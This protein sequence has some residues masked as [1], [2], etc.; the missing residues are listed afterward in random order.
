MTVRTPIIEAIHNHIKTNPLSFHVPGHKNGVIATR[1]LPE[2]KQ[3]FSYDL[4]ELDG[5]DDL[6]DASGPIKASQALCAKYYGA[7]E[8]SYLVGGSTS[9]NLA[10][11]YGVCHEG[12]LVFVQRNCHKS[13]LNALEF[14]RVNVVFLEPEKSPLTG[15]AVG[16]TFE[17]LKE[18]LLTYPYAKAIIMTYPDY[19]GT[20]INQ[21]EL[22]AEAKQAGL[23]VL[24]DEAHGAHFRIGE[25]DK[26]CPQSALS[27]GADVVVQSTHKMLPSL[28]MSAWMHYSYTLNDDIKKRIKRALSMFQ[29][30][31]PSYLLL[32]SLDA[33]RAHIEEEGVYQY[34]QTLESKRLLIE[35]LQE[36]MGLAIVE[37]VGDAYITDP[38][39]I[40]VKA[41]NQS[42]R[43]L[44]SNLTEL[45]IWVEMADEEHVLFVL[46]LGENPL[47]SKNT[48]KSLKHVKNDHLDSSS[49]KINVTQAVF[50]VINF[51]PADTSTELVPLRQ[52]VDR[53]SAVEIIPYPPGVPLLYR[54]EKINRNHIKKIEQ[55]LANEI[56]FQGHQP[57]QGIIVKVLGDEL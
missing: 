27:I 7:S 4:T 10:M 6:H 32:A 39:K 28:T 41:P 21:E 45:G 5:L 8:T 31:S 22:F 56:R 38:F 53:F 37:H 18:A 55:L 29:S 48:F 34:K 19:W 52:A 26:S 57:N 25:D 51:K 12:D 17:T 15:H 11:V 23:Y 3:I 49:N 9:G 50:E 16:L 2:F 42:G 30:S 35:Y 24:V 33:A 20:V 1:F 44:L 43:S 54:G 36:E 47:P 46:G 40:I 14:A 13:I